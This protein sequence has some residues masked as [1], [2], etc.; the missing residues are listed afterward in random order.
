MFNWGYLWLEYNPDTNCSEHSQSRHRDLWRAGIRSLLL[1]FAFISSHRF[2]FKTMVTV[3]FSSPTTSCTVP[4]VNLKIFLK[5]KKIFYTNIFY[6]NLFL[7]PKSLQTKKFRNWNFV[8]LQ[9][10]VQGPGVDFSLRI[11]W[12]K[13]FL[14]LNFFWN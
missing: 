8:K 13:I 4:F 6:R 11:F 5:P 3:V 2:L 12:N 7:D 1:V 10:Q 14:E 9:F